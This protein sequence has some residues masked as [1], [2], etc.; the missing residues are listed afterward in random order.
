MTCF[1]RHENHYNELMKYLFFIL[2]IY[3]CASNEMV[4]NREKPQMISLAA[5]VQPSLTHKYIYDELVMNAPNYSVSQNHEGLNKHF[6]IQ[7]KTSMLCHP[8]ALATSLIQE[9]KKNKKAKELKLNGF[10]ENDKDVDANELVHQLVGCTNS[11]AA[12][13][14][15]YQDS[16]KCLKRIYHDSN[17]DV[18]INLI[19][20]LSSENKKKILKSEKHEQRIASIQDIVFYLKGGYHVIGI[21]DYISPSEKGTWTRSGGHAIVINGY[22][23]QQ[24]WPSDLL[25]IFI[26]DPALTY[27]NSLYPRFD[28]ALITK[29]SNTKKFPER[30]GNLSFEGNSHMGITSRAILTGLLVYKTK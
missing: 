8:S 17:I 18:D 12:T 6:N 24:S 29:V 16:A 23:R 4:N 14:T 2:Y 10:S 28:Q 20:E 26:S 15:Y 27:N 5:D 3:S 21:V 30:V 9:R 7:D 13:G 11:D 19:V 22:A 25:Y 1:V